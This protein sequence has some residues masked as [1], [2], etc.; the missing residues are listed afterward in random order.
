MKL[1]TDNTEQQSH[2]DA[3]AEAAEAI[4]GASHDDST[5]G[6]DSSG[7]DELAAMQMER[8]QARETALRAYAELDNYRKRVQREAELAARYQEQYLIRDLLPALDNLNRTV[9]AA[10][11]TS[12]VDDLIQ[13]LKM[14][15]SQVDQVL[16]NHSAKPIVAVGQPFDPNLHEAIQQI[17][18]PDH[19]PMTVLQ[20]AE[21][22]YMLHDRVIR[23]AKVLVAS[24]PPA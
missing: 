10:E 20:E 9:E 19:P 2:D 22:G 11:R 15:L 8:D 17:P 3:V 23:P 4:A 7:V 6:S 12:N 13:G 1:M 16:G 14:I 18:T 5:T 21:R 24:A